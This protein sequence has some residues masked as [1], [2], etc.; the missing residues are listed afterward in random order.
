MYT[1]EHIT[2]VVIPE[3]QSI[4]NYY[5]G[6]SQPDSADYFQNQLGLWQQI[7]DTNHQDIA[8]GDSLDNISFSGGL[9][10]SN[11]VTTTRS[12]TTSFDFNFYIDYGVA[13]DVGASIAGLGIFGGVAVAG[14]STWGSVV[15][16]DA[17]TSTNVGYVLSDDD[18]GDSYTLDIIN[19][20]VYGTPAFKLLAGQSSC[21]WE[22]GTLPREGVQLTSNT[23]SQNVEE[24]QQAVFILQLGNTSQSNE[25]RT[26]NLVFDYTSNPDGAV[27]LLT[28]ARLWETHHSR[29]PYRQGSQ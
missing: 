17:S 8:H 15:E 11:S 22:P 23:Y 24:T 9:I 21:P 12:S 6:V 10:Y 18:I 13:V 14:R 16:N 1:E 29:L 5:N 4:V 19:D 27:L 2:D 26:Y 3:L 28:E 25:T 20:K 7:V